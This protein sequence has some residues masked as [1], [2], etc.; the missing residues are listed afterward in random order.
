MFPGL[1]ELLLIG[2]SFESIWS[3][4]S[5]SNT[6]TPKNQLAD[7]LNKGK[8]RTWWTE[9]SFELN[10][11][12]FSSAECSEVMST[13]TQKESGEERVTAQSRPM[14]S[15]IA[16]SS[17]R[18][19]S[20]L[21][22]S[23]SESHPKRIYKNQSPLSMQAE[24]YDGTVKPVVCRDPSHEQGHHYRFCK[25]NTSNDPFSRFKSVQ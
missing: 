25:D 16:R 23:A 13:R 5:K 22:S 6:L 1:T 18:P 24:K 3:P 15:L 21:S 14:M 11:S 10:I 7:M 8:F 17:E 4:K 19:P 9:A 20:A 12:H 2:C